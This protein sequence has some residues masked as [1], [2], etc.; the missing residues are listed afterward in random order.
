[1]IKEVH[2]WIASGH[3]SRPKTIG[4]LAPNYYWPKIKDEVYCYI[5]KCYICRRA[6]TSKYQYNNL[7]KSLP[8]PAHS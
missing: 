5:E 8:I 2:D 1:M 4:F 6:K 7:L 3:L